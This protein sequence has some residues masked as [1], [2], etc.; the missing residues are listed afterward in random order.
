MKP[1]DNSFWFKLR[2]IMAHKDVL[3]NHCKPI[4]NW[5]IKRFRRSQ[6][7]AAHK[8]KGKSCLEVA[9]FLSVP[10]MWK[11]DALF[12]AMRSN[13]RYHPYVVVFPYS[14]YKEYDKEELRRM[15]QRTYD[16]I[17][18]KIGARFFPSSYYFY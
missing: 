12:E 11:H 15:L 4:T 13:S 7:Q 10:G 2:V 9:L 17:V 5:Y 18:N 1:I 8:L 16:F 6:L 3:R 14:T